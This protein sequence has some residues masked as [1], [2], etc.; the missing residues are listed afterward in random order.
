MNIFYHATKLALLA[1]LLL[2]ATPGLAQVQ[3]EWLATYKGTGT[4]FDAAIAIEA[5]LQ[6]NVYVTGYSYGDGSDTDYA[7]I[8]YDAAGNE[9]WVRR[10]DGPGGGSDQATALAVDDAGNVYVTGTSRGEEFNWDYATIK[11]TTGGD[12]LWV[13]RYDGPAGGWD[14]AQDVLVDA[15]GNVYVTGRS[16]T[17]KDESAITTIQYN[18]AGVEQW[19]AT[20]QGSDPRSNEG[21]RLAVDA[22]GNVYVGGNSS[23]SGSSMDFAIIKY[24][25]DGRE[26]W[27]ARYDGP[28]HSGDYLYN[29]TIDAAGAVYVT[30]TAIMGFDEEDFSLRDMVTIRYTP[31]GVEDWVRYYDGGGDDGGRALAV[32]EAGNVYVT[33]QSSNSGPGEED[34]DSDF[35][36]LKYS[37]SGELLWQDRYNGPGYDQGSTPRAMVLDAAGN[38][39][40]T[41]QSSITGYF[42]ALDIATLKYSPSGELLWLISYSGP[43]EYGDR[44][45]DLALD[46]QGNVYVTG[47]ITIADGYES[48]YITLKYSQQGQE[49]GCD[50]NPDKVEVCHKGKTLCISRKAL[51]AHL[52]HGDGAGACAGEAGL[53]ARSMVETLPQDLRLMQYPNPASD[54]TTL[55]YELPFAGQLTI[56]LYDMQGREMALLVEARQQSGT[57][58]TEVKVAGLPQGS[59]VV[60][61]RLQNGKQLLE[62]NRR[63]LVVR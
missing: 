13:A 23:G 50:G 20:Y 54:I 36:T 7:T 35:I 16:T 17:A 25:A 15:A 10:Y 59:Y 39:Y 2:Y 1:V 29:M 43:A 49:V 8:K 26:L 58:S 28:A 62:Q 52:N 11:Y 32:D 33:G 46:A 5:D 19:V 51:A 14:I 31:E 37:A 3:L 61:C 55:V 53:S 60:R 24:D 40:I 30:G 34:P 6:G 27:V 18:A 22:Q 48:A 21:I 47:N 38:V 41:G 44:G 45:A 57:Y 63:L 56:R 4:G 9:L 12:S 42:D